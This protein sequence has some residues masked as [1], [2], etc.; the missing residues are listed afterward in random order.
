MCE[1]VRNFAEKYVAE[2][3]DIVAAQTRATERAAAEKK[4]ISMVQN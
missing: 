1:A 3:A 4:Q 2:M